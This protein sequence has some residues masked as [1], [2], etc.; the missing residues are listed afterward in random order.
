MLANACATRRPTKPID[1]DPGNERFG[2][3]AQAAGER[4]DGGT[5]TRKTFSSASYR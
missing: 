5:P 3:H 2:T 1:L 4:M